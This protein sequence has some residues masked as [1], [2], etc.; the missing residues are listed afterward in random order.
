M[1]EVTGKR[2]ELQVDLPAT[3]PHV[4][5]IRARR[6]RLLLG[7]AA[8]PTVYTLM[9]G[10]GVAAASLNCWDAPST[11]TAAPARVTAAP[12]QWARAPIKSGTDGQNSNVMGYCLKDPSE[13]IAGA[14]SDPLKPDWSAS[15]TYWYVQGQ[16]TLEARGGIR[17][18]P[19]TPGYGLLYIDRAGKV[20][21]F[22]PL[23]HPGVEL[24]YAS[25]ACMNSIT[26]STKSTLG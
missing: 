12:D 11:Q 25:I 1:S 21:A 17:N 15:Q 8:V 19:K 20:Q 2:D 5:L 6:R 22:D 23:Q 10:A 24:K 9:S 7:A 4:D 13:Q 26:L 14:C 3:D 16:R 18:I